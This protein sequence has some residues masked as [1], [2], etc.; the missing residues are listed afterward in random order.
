ML[1]LN[2]FSIRFCGVSIAIM[3]TELTIK[4]ASNQNFFNKTRIYNKTTEHHI[5]YTYMMSNPHHVPGLVLI[6]SKQNVF[7]F[8]LPII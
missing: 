4:T 8:H 5:R 7:G 3:D 2:Y 1:R 6:S